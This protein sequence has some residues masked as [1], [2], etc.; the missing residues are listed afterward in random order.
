MICAPDATTVVVS[1]AAM[2]VVIFLVVS[3]F[4]VAFLTAVAEGVKNDPGPPPRI[5]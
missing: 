3:A 4:A 2:R 1:L 5:R